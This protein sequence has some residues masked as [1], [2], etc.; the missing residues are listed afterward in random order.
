V[1][2]PTGRRTYLNDQTGTPAGVLGAGDMPVNFRDDGD[3]WLPIELRWDVVNPT[4]W[5][6]V[7]GDHRVIVD[8]TV[9]IQFSKRDVLGAWH[10]LGMQPRWLVKFDVA[11]RT[12]DTLA[13]A[14]S[15][16]I[17]IEAGI[18]KLSNVFPDVHCELEYFN[19]SFSMEWVFTQAARDALKSAGP[20]AGYAIGIATEL[21][22][23]QMN[24][25]WRDESGGINPALADVFHATWIDVAA[26]GACVFALPPSVLQHTAFDPFGATIP[27][28]KFIGKRD[29]TWWLIEMF[30]PIAANVLPSG[31]VWHHATFG[32][33]GTPGTYDYGLD[34]AIASNRAAPSSNG[35]ATSI[36]YYCRGTGGLFGS[37][38]HATCALYTDG[39][40]SS[41]YQE[42]NEVTF[43]HGDVA[44]TVFHWQQFNFGTTPSVVNGT[45]YNIAIWGE[46]VDA[47]SGIELKATLTGG[48]NKYDASEVYATP[49]SWP[50]LSSSNAAIVY[51]YCTYTAAGGAL[52]RH[53][54][55]DGGM[56]RQMKGGIRG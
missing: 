15:P 5:R 49:L 42:T 53:R 30:D 20:W 41:Y 38:T 36:T 12:W 25:Q 40:P 13:Q 51:G 27:V 14:A 6:A 48:Y 55:M 44:Y 1:L 34:D 8:S 10:R 22:P 37:D 7:Q 17:S 3:V 9:G 16:L 43:I 28:R 35:T 24:V 29:G 4:R 33:G 21:D 32:E 50:A 18:M 56:N 45:D 19:N 11:N 39:S 46:Y 26:G 23:S 2:I 52:L 54:G 31:D 47:S